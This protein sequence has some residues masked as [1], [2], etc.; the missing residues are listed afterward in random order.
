MVMMHIP[1]YYSGE[2]HGT[3]HCRELFAPLFDKY[4]IDLFIAGH[5]HKFGV[6]DPVPGKHSY[7]IIIGGGPKE[8]TRTLIKVKAL[9]LPHEIQGKFIEAVETEL[10]N[11]HEGNFARYMIKPSEFENWQEVWN[12]A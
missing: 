2:A 12:D 8:G 9:Q 11:L 5:T 7:P 10:L 6:F 4:K 1:H 3:L